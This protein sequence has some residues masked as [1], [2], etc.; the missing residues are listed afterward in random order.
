M[1][2]LDLS[3]NP[4]Q[5]EVEW[6]AH[7]SVYGYWAEQL[8]EAQAEYDE[9]KTKCDIVKATVDQEVRENPSAFSVD[10][11][12]VDTVNSATTL[13]PRMQAAI[14]RMNAAKKKTGLCK[15]AVDALEHK[16]RALTVLAELWIKDYYS[17]LGMPKTE[18]LTEE[19]KKAIRSRGRARRGRESHDNLTD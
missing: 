4:L 6:T 10:K 9:L 5:L 3:I 15:A 14:T 11:V 18:H 7:P 8:V 2:H 17:E 19:D 1:K 12:T 16:K 13:D